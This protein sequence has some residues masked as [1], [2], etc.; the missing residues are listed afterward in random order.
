V[1]GATLDRIG[2]CITNF[3]D[4]YSKEFNRDSALMQAQRYR[5]QGL[6]ALSRRVFSL[7]TKIDINGAAVLEV[8]GGVGA[9]SLELLKAGGAMAVNVELSRS[10][11]DAA[12]ALALEDGLQNRIDL[13]AADGVEAI[14]GLGSFDVVVLNRV[15]CCYHKGKDLLRV[16]ADATDNMLIASYPT[17][18]LLSKGLIAIGNRLNARRGCSV[19]P[20]IHSEEELGEPSQRGLVEVHRKARPVWT[21]RAWTRPAA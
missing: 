21:V 12:A 18:H 1:I 14:G 11:R 8:G 6:D 9:L 10:Y 16:S 5:L 19:H 17:I 20:F 15:L 7:A 4:V 2:G 3:C 13:V